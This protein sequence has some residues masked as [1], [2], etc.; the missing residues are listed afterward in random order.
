MQ[1]LTEV[2]QQEAGKEPLEDRF[3]VGYI[4]AIKDILQVTFEEIET[5]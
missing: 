3:R 5:E 4:A 2:L 1:I